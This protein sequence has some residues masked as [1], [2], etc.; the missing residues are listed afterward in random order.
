MDL[1]I[2]F[3]ESDFIS[4]G[5]I[6]RNGIAVS[7]SYSIFKGLF[8]KKTYFFDIIKHCAKWEKGLERTQMTLGKVVTK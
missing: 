2:S 4:F 5:Y 1:Q 3:Q 7:H 6:P 8:L